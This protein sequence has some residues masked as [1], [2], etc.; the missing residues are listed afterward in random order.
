[1]LMALGEHCPLERM[2]DPTVAQWL[3]SNL[4][5]MIPQGA[6]HFPKVAQIDDGHCILYCIVLKA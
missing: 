6:S 4:N 3:V 1:M 2:A 5:G